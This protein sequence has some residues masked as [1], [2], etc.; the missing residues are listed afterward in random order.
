MG[1]GGDLYFVET[2]QKNTNTKDDEYCTT[3]ATRISSTKSALM[4]R[5]ELIAG[6]DSDSLASYIPNHARCEAAAETLGAEWGGVE[7]NRKGYHGLVGCFVRDQKVYWDPRNPT[8]AK[9]ARN[10]ICRNQDRWKDKMGNCQYH[11][12]SEC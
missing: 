7:T 3:P 2:G 11:K 4:T 10:A 5:E 8:R 6:G 1:M 12:M 9:E